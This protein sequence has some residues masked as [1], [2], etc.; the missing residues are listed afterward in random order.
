MNTLPRLDD[1]NRGQGGGNSIDKKGESNYMRG[2]LQIYTFYNHRGKILVHLTHS[3][4]YHI[5]LVSR[6]QKN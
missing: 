6:H 3:S 2:I 1:M 4:L 5:S